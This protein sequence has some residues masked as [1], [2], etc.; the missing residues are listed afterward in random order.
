VA[1]PGTS[2]LTCQKYRRSHLYSGTAPARL[3]RARPGGRLWRGAA[4]VLVLALGLGGCSLS[5]QFDSFFPSNKDDVT[6]SIMPPPGAKEAAELPPDADLVYA[7][8]AVTEVLSRGRKDDSLPWE[9]PRSGARGTVTPI[10][11]AYSSGEQTCHDFLASHVQGSSQAWLQ[12][13]ACKPRKGVWQVRSMKPW[14]RS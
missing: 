12:G 1:G 4:A 7:R 3:W 10:A 9:N 14:K 2:H 13:E 8:A 5:S 6:G 11:S